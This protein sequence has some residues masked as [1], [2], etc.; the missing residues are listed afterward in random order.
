M[1]KLNVDKALIAELAGLLDKTNLSEIEWSEG[2]IQVRVARQV[3]SST[4]VVAGQPANPPPSA[5]AASTAEDAAKHPGAVKSPMVGTVYYASE[6]GA[7]PFVRAGD[8][9][10]AGQ[11]VMIVEAMKTMNPIPAHKGGRIKQVL[12]AN[13]EPV[14]YG[15]ALVI[16]E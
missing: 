11:T 5:P 1:P 12:V 3:T 4:T 10:S 8:T 6:P 13:A 15:Q 2:G 14:E 16:I 7:A 9:V